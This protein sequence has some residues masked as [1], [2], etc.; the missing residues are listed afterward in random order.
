[1]NTRNLYE[2]LVRLRNDKGLAPIVEWIQTLREDSR[3]RLETQ[4]DNVQVEQGKAQAFKKILEAIE[5]SPE[6]LQTIVK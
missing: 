3:A 1:M 2:A 4:V 5:K 6:I